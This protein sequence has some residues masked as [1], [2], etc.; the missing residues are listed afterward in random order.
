MNLTPILI[1][2]RNYKE[3]VQLSSRRFYLDLWKSLMSPLLSW[4]SCIKD[5]QQDFVYE[6]ANDH[7]SLTKVVDPV[8]FVDDNKLVNVAVP[9]DVS[10]CLLEKEI[11]DRSIEAS[12]IT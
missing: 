2:N 9:S 11:F 6:E 10:D 4:C 1:K 5:S 7:V 12:T 3:K 8:V